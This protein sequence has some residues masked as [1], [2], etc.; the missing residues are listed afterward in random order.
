MKKSIIL[1]IGIIVSITASA[2]NVMRGN[3]HAAR[4]DY[5]LAIDDYTKAIELDSRLAEAYYNRGIIR[6]ENTHTKNAGIADLSKAG[7]LGIYDAYG[8][9]KRKTAKK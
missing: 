4:K 5:Q 3:F 1:L 6:L 2:Q 9:I 8:V 7:E